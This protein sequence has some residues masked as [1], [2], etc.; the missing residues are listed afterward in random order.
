MKNLIYIAVLIAIYYAIRFLSPDFTIE[1]ISTLLVGVMLLSS[2]LFS[3]LIKKIKLPRLTGYMLMG[4]IL[5][6]SGIGILTQDVVDNL[7]FLENLALSFIALTAG[8]ELRFD[9]IRKYRRSLGWILSGQI[10]IIFTGMVGAFYLIAGQIK[11]FTELQPLVV[12]G[13]SVLF[14][15]TALSTSPAT[16]IGIITELQSAGKI[17]NF[18]LIIT[19]LK[20][21]FLILV[22]PVIITMSRFL[23]VESGSFNLGVLK[24][25]ILQLLASFAIGIIMGGVIIWYLKKVKVEMSIF[26][27]GAILAITEV[28]SLFGLEILLTSLV[29]GIVVQNFS[30][31]GN[32][33]I[34]NIE[35]FSLPVYVIFFCFA[36]ASLHLEILGQMLFVTLFLVVARLVLNY[37]GNLAGA[38]IAGESRLVRNISWMGYIG[39]A[40]I[41]L[42]LGII[43]E[44]N[45]P[46]DIGKYFFAILISTVVLNEMIGPVL[47]KYVFIKSGEA[48]NTE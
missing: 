7:Q 19:V 33:L 18:V 31:Y 30:K 17:T 22:F 4:A 15:G 14:A 45:L 16:T 35:V 13:F 6:T 11:F 10:I 9:I 5:G 34:T 47:L 38:V 42:G 25:I 41:A 3:N 37:L 40:G 27:L 20:A 21:I 24:E 36:G 28:S 2:Y 23:F 1:E 48:A 44:K 29:T 39:Q 12:L 46:S 26:L 32:R 8:G 43:I